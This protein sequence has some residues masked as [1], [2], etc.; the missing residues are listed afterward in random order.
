MVVITI[1]VLTLRVL[2]GHLLPQQLVIVILVLVK[3][4]EVY[5]E[6]QVIWP[7][8]SWS[9]DSVI[10]ETAYK[11]ER[12]TT[13]YGNNAIEWT[14][15][16]DPTYHNGVGLIYPSDYGF[17]VGGADREECLATG[18]MDRY[19]P[20]FDFSK[21]GSNE[22]TRYEDGYYYA[23]LS[24][25]SNGNVFSGLYFTGLSSNTPDDLL[26]VHPSVYLKSNYRIGEGTGSSSDPYHLI[27]T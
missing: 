8:G 5:Q 18:T 23:Y 3:I 19:Y 9:D 26:S 2:L 6:Q 15:T 27:E 11:N 20:M 21:C 16:N 22:W 10:P 24:P 25:T 17:S 1:V 4:Q 12:G 7:L 14:K 13:K